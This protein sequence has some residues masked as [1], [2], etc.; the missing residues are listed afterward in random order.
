MKK[1]YLL[2]TLIAIAFMLSMSVSAS[3]MYIDAGQ[4][5]EI[6]AN[7][8]VFYVPSH[9]SPYNVKINFYSSSPCNYENTNGEIIPTP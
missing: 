1:L 4:N 5:V 2:L 9:I 3:D 8:N 7:D 6:E